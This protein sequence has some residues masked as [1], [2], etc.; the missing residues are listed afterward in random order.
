MNS[1]LPRNSLTPFWFSNRKYPF[2]AGNNS[3]FIVYKNAVI[4]KRER[5]KTI[6]FISALCSGLLSV[7]SPE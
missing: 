5:L 7:F 4:K 1:R 3:I 2:L 6:T